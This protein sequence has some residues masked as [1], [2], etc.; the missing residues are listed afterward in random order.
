MRQKTSN[1]TDETSVDKDKAEMR[2]RQCA[3]DR[4]R[5][6]AVKSWAVGCGRDIGAEQCQNQPRLG[7]MPDLGRAI[8]DQE[9]GHM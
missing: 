2:L 8:A 6:C 1:G 7:A 4:R 9:K 3:A 5:A